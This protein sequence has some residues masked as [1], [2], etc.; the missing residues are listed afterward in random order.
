MKKFMEKLV[1]KVRKGVALACASGGD[2]QG[3]FRG[4][5]S[6]AFF[7]AFFAAF[8]VAF[9]ATF[10]VAFFVAFFVMFF[11]AFFMALYCFQGAEVTA[12]LTHSFSE[13]TSLPSGSGA[14]PV[15]WH[16][17]HRA[18]LWRIFNFLTEKETWGM[19]KLSFD[20]PLVSSTA[21]N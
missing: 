9:F 19:D 8:F 18:Q 1:K 4:F 6:R 2:A 15:H 3:F 7:V 10:F 16:K 11:V 17:E 20:S 14:L 12:S 5:F 13:L 21:A